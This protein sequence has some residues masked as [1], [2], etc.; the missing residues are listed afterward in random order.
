DGD[1]VHGHADELLDAAD[2]LS[3][4]GGQVAE[5]TGVGD[6]LSPAGQFFVDR[7]GPLH[8][9][10]RGGQRG[11]ALAVQLVRDADLDALERGEGVEAGERHGGDAVEP[12]R[13][14]GE[15]AIEPSD[16]TRASGGGA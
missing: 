3:G 5:V 4:L 7:R 9:G 8:G 2:V 13:V 16:T 11:D 14:A 1:H 12:G 15:D 6:V 10:E